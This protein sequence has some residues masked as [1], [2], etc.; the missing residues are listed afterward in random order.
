MFA[1]AVAVVTAGVQYNPA[2][3]V[4]GKQEQDEWLGATHRRQTWQNW[5]VGVALSLGSRARCGHQPAHKAQ[6]LLEGV[7]QESNSERM[8]NHKRRNP[9]NCERHSAPE[10]ALASSTRS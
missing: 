9:H 7:N 4:Q 3:E 2:C 10:L 5:T 1:L 8:P 6:T